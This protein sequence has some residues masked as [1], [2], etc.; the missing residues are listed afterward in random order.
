MRISEAAE[1]LGVSPNTLRNLGNAG[2]IADHRQPVNGYRLFKQEE[3]DKLLRPIQSGEANPPEDTAVRE[4]QPNNPQTNGR[5]KALDEFVN[6][7]VINN[8]I[9]IL[10]IS[11]QHAQ[12]VTKLP[13]HHKD[14]FDRL[15]IAQART[16]GMTILS[17]DD[18]FGDDGVAQIW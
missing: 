8:D 1:F 4:T 11:T 10:P 2:K 18:Q 15:L 5:P 7:E 6:R 16:E 13:F 14:P 3:L 9:S 17:K 12:T